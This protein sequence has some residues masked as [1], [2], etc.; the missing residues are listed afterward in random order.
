LIGQM[1]HESV[2]QNTGG[3]TLIICIHGKYSS[4]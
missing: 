4:N 1:D 3:V 2:N